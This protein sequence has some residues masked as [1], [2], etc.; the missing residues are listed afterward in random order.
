M[1]GKIT[2][3]LRANLRA[4]RAYWD[5]MFTELRIEVSQEVW[6]EAH[7][8]LVEERRTYPSMAEGMRAQ[9]HP[10]RFHELFLAHYIPSSVYDHADVPYYRNPEFDDPED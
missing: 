1:A 7:R 8:L 2:P 10:D 9:V 4:Y 6:R 3:E 5:L